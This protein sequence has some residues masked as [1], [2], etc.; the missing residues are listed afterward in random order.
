MENNGVCLLRRIE[1]GYVLTT[2]GQITVFY[3]SI[4][5]AFEGI[6]KYIAEYDGVSGIQN[7]KIDKNA[8]EL[9]FEEDEQ[10]FEHLRKVRMDLA[11]KYN[12]PPYFIFHDSTL[13]NIVRERPQTKEE[14]S[15]VRGVGE[16]GAEKYGDVFL[17]AIREHMDQ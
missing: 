6:K 2:H 7:V 10:L 3:K 13:K 1:N 9:I 15:K 17:K 14:M 4:E 11:T 12:Y 16:G 8:P 5:E